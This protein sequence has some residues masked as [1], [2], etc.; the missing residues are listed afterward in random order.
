MQNPVLTSKAGKSFAMGVQ[1]CAEH[2]LA[3]GYDNVIVLIL[4]ASFRIRIVIRMT[5]THGH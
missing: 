1:T 4:M 2:L 5:M 3:T